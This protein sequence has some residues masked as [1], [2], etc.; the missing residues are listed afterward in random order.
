MRYVGIAALII[1]FVSAV[2][3]PIAMVIFRRRRF[4][5]MA[6][7]VSC[8]AMA[9]A[10]AAL[11]FLLI[12]GDYSAEYVFRNTDSTLPLIYRISA[13]WSSS[14]GS[15]MLWALCGSV[16]YLLIRLSRRGEAENRGFT[17]C[18]SVTVTAVNFL[19]LVFILFIN[20]PFRYA[21]ANTDGL[22]LNP[23][24]QSPG[25]VI[26]P[27]LVMIAYSLL[28]VAFAAALY[29]LVYSD[30]AEKSTGERFSLLGWI[31]LTLGIVSG[32]IW[33][34]NELGWGG[35]WS[36]DAI[37]NSAFVTWL[38]CS[39]YIHLH[40]LRGK[41]A[42]GRKTLFILSA[43][44]VFSILFG[45]FI[46]RSGVIDSVHAYTGRSSSTLFFALVLTA[47]AVIF[48]AVY[49]ISR[50]GKKT[51]KGAEGRSF[52][53]YLPSLW[54]ILCAIVIGAMTLSPLLPIKADVGEKT[55]DKVFGT[56]GTALMVMMC[57]GFAAARLPKKRAAVVSLAAL[58][59]GTALALM[60][61]FAAYGAFTRV[62]LALNAAC[63]AA[64]C[65]GFVADS[66]RFLKSGAVFA[67]FILHL[68]LTVTAIG[69]IGSRGMKTELTYILDPGDHFY[70]SGHS[71][72][73]RSFETEREGNSVSRIFALHHEGKGRESDGEISMT[74]DEKQG[75]YT[76]KPMVIRTAGEDL[77]LIAENF[78]D[79]GGLQLKAIVSRW[80]SFLWAGIGLM[81]LSAICIYIGKKRF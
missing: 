69:L 17:N 57:A 26:H 21:G 35:Y 68:A 55:Y 51:E 31:V 74:L 72:E 53:R 64:M 19:F 48:A 11:L 44:T 22:G 10:S 16:I 32:G 37:E 25:M 28:F 62:L 41:N 34:Y 67:V 38:L 8:G 13:F 81:L 1:S 18:L 36:W 43:A 15:M 39:A 4:G 54:M 30:G 46:A 27:P 40:T 20:D 50:R 60:P 24:L 63:L 7:A 23:T 75:I 65:F 52:F 2:L 66:G 80:I 49:I 3:C 33:A 59:V 61:G 79:D 56:G 58:A 6:A 73:Y 42:V 70:L 71:V 9:A 29:E 14:S 47:A 5:A 76:S 77:F 45:T 12:S 78:A